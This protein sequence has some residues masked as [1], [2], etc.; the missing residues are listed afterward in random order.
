MA[1]D[2]KPMS[3]EEDCIT[4]QNTEFRSSEADTAPLNLIQR[5]ERWRQRRKIQNLNG[6]IFVSGFGLFADGYLSGV[7]S[8][9]WIFWAMV[10]KLTF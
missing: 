1:V 9:T 2:D 4:E 6:R 8:L 10:N 7:S 5:V 3:E